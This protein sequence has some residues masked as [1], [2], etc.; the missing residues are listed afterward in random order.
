MKV[1]YTQM[2]PR[3]DGQVEFDVWLLQDDETPLGDAHRTVVLPGKVVLALAGK[4]AE[5][6]QTAVTAS[7]K[8]FRGVEE[9]ETALISM[10]KIILDEVATWGYLDS[11]S[12]YAV[13]TELMSGVKDKT[14]DVKAAIETI[15]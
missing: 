15:K 6:V 10:E 2:A 3:G 5:E 8:V 4:T 11:Y 13:V 7:A 9:A 14:I 12:G 1:K